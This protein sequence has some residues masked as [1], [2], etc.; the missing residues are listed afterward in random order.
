MD[1]QSVR[2]LP[3]FEV[4]IE[5]ENA[6]LSEL[7]RALRMLRG[8]NAQIGALKLPGR[9]KVWIVY[10]ADEIDSSVIVHAI[11]A[12]G[13][14]G[15]DASFEAIIEGVREQ[16]YY[17]L[18]TFGAKRCASEV[19]VFIDSDVVPED[20]WLRGLLEP[21]A[22]DSVD[23]V[24]GTA[25]V[26]PDS[27]VARAFALFW[28]FPLRTS[29]EGLTPATAGFAN[30]V[31]FRRAIYLR[32][33]YPELPQFRGQCSALWRM[34]VSDRVGFFCQ[35]GARVSHPAPNGFK[36]F[37]LRAL[38]HGH[39]DVAEARRRGDSVRLGGKGQLSALRG[40]LRDARNRIL[41]GRRSVGLG[42]VGALAALGL[43][44]S[45]NVIRFAGAM[46]AIRRPEY[47]IH[48]IRV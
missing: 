35:H 36:H 8:L 1:E 46:L 21:F 20:G 28:F 19:I 25:F 39:D 48:R 27:F 37:I 26:E 47:L 33:P 38:A 34:L 3:E 18:K 16:R 44:A 14:S 30:N 5:W 31:A 4:V 32:R 9:P 24:A 10:D 17:Q 29:L 13:C 42:P 15:D 6:R 7:H 41:A 12:A 2:K 45:F 11:D 23:V 22:D 43:A 40:R